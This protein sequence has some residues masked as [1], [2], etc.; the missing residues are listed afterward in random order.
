MTQRSLIHFVVILLAIGMI[1]VVHAELVCSDS[2][3]GAAITGSGVRG[4][5]DG[6][7]LKVGPGVSATWTIR[8]AN[9]KS[10]ELVEASSPEGAAPNKQVYRISRP[11]P[12]K[13][14]WELTTLD[15]NAVTA[16]SLPQGA[17]LALSFKVR[18]RTFP[19]DSKVA[20][21]L[22]QKDTAGT[23]NLT[24]VFIRPPSDQGAYFFLSGPQALFQNSTMQVGHWYQVRQ[25]V[26]LKQQTYFTTVKDLDGGETSSNSAPVP[27]IADKTGGP[28]QVNQFAI[29]VASTNSIDVEV[30][31]VRLE[32]VNGP[33][34][35]AREP[36]TLPSG[37]GT[38]Q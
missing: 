21:W 2:F 3:E 13:G 5:I 1:S 38:G 35:S 6:A 22:R 8:T 17:E 36:S 23:R 30:D 10:H 7:S 37:Q 18:W 11:T 28:R 29:E 27:L 31:D 12:G 19:Q 34:S 16:D 15:F 20:F 32:I 9:L 33:A 26:D 24:C 4:A 14:N 25:T